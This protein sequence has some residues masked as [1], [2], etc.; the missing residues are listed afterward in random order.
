M[1]KLSVKTVKVWTDEATGLFWVYRLTHGHRYHHKNYIYLESTSSLTS[2]STSANVLVPRN[3]ALNQK[4]WE[5]IIGYTSRSVTMW[6]SL[7]RTASVAIYQAAVILVG[8]AVYTESKENA[9]R[10]W[11]PQLQTA[12]PAAVWQEI[13]RRQL[14]YLFQTAVLQNDK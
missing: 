5:A 7:P 6:G 11:L 14:L 1:V 4:A 3:T 10:K 12:H 8:W 2:Y 9:Q 13:Q